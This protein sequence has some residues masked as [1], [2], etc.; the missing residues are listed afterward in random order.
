MLRSAAVIFCL[1]GFSLQCE[2][3]MR[4]VGQ[5]IVLSVHFSSISNI[6]ENLDFLLIEKLCMAHGVRG[7][8]RVREGAGGRAA[9]QLQL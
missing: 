6:K 7:Q 5:V 4:N 9:R 1:L 2:I 8:Q 3:I